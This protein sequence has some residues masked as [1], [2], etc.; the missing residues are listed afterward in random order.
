MKSLHNLQ[1]HKGKNDL[2]NKQFRI[3]YPLFNSVHPGQINER[4]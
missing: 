2:Q 3:L 1:K 4:I